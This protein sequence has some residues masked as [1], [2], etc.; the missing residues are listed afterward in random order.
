VCPWLLPRLPLLP[1][2]CLCTVTLPTWL[3]ML[4]RRSWSCLC[5]YVSARRVDDAA[6]FVL[7]LWG[8]WSAD[9]TGYTC[10][11]YACFCSASTSST[12]ARTL[13]TA[14]LCKNL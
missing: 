1:R 8:R 3:A 10:H 11:L 9:N 2:E 4:A 13:A 14:L 12:A 5:R 6:W 7:C